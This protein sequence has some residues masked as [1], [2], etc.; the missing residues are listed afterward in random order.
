MGVTCYG[1]PIWQLTASYP[2][3]GPDP[4]GC[5]GGDQYIGYIVMG[6]S[7]PYVYNYDWEQGSVRYSFPAPGGAGA[8]GIALY[9]G[10]YFFITNNRTSW[11]YE[12]TGRGSL[13]NSFRC[14]LDG[15][16]DC[17]F[18]WPGFIVAIPDRNVIALLDY[19][20][21]SLLGSYPG[22]GSKPIGYGGYAHFYV[23]DSET[24]NVYE[25]GV[26]VITGIQAPIGFS[27]RWSYAPPYDDA[28]YVIDDAT[29]RYYYYRRGSG[30]GIGPASLGRV[31]A[32]YW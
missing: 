28:L 12:T 14:P 9:S 16:A 31:K 8:W 18:A 20:T 23:A 5:Q 29:D 11:I 17:S 25:D 15:P 27:Y 26:P 32:L 1:T 6:G 24:H 21:G 19:T 2:T 22:P 4:R 10:S 30:S 13:V 7:N 3:P